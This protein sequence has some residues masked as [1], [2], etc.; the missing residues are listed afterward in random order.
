MA[1]IKPGESGKE[2]HFSRE[3]FLERKKLKMTKPDENNNSVAAPSLTSSGQ[4]D[5]MQGIAEIPS[6][7]STLSSAETPT[8]SSETS[9]VSFTQKRE[10][11]IGTLGEE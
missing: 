7:Q 4:D 10:M 2:P 8:P 3:S 6:S 5:T 1:D 9:S 11:L